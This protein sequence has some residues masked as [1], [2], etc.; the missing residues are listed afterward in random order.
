MIMWRTLRTAILASLIGLVLAGQAGAGEI[1]VGDSGGEAD[2]LARSRD[3]ARSYVDPGRPGTVVVVPSDPGRGNE[4][5]LQRNSERAREYGNPSTLP[6]GSGIIIVAPDPLAP[7]ASGPRGNDR[8]LQRNTDRARDY[9]NPSPSGGV[10]IVVPGSG[11]SDARDSDLQRS[12]AVTLQR[13]R[14]RAKSYGTGTNGTQT[15][16]IS[17]GTDPNR[18]Q[19]DNATRV[20]MNTDKARSYLG[21]SGNR[22]GCSNSQVIVGRIEGTASS[23][24]VSSVVTGSDAV[25][26]G[27]ECR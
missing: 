13:S 12:N 11:G 21:E 26:S 6:P 20:E 23:G 8:N 17:P 1:Y 9:V 22:P 7:A 18:S 19:M 14:N 16:I 15:I 3:A 5:N 27:A 25:V 4:S 10:T 24:R 2:P